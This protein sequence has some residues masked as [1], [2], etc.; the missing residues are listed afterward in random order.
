MQHMSLIRPIQSTT[1]VTEHSIATYFDS[2]TASKGKI[3]FD[4][5]R[6]L[7]C[8]YEGPDDTEYAVIEGQVQGTRSS[9]YSVIIIFDPDNDE[10]ISSDCSCPVEIDCK[11]G[12]ALMYKL[13]A[14]SFGHFTN[15][16]SSIDNSSIS[17][18]TLDKNT[19]VDS[20]ASTNV[21][22]PGL[23]LKQ[24]SN[25]STE[26]S[27]EWLT[28]IRALVEHTNNRKVKECVI[29]VLQKIPQASIHQV[30]DATHQITVSLMIGRQ[31]QNGE[32]KIVRPASNIAQMLNGTA[33]YI[34]KEDKEIAGLFIE[35]QT[36]NSNGSSAFPKD[37][38]V[39]EFLLHRIISTGRCLWAKENSILG[40][41]SA[42]DNGKALSLSP[43]KPGKVIWKEYDDG[44]QE[45]ISIVHKASALQTFFL[46][47]WYYIDTHEHSIGLLNLDLPDQ[48]LK[49]LASKRVDPEEATAIYIELSKSRRKLAIPLPK[50]NISTELI[51][52]RPKPVLTLVTQKRDHSSWLFSR[53]FYGHLQDI[54][55]AMLSF[56]YDGITFNEKINEHHQLIDNKLK[57][58]RRHKTA[59]YEFSAE[60][61]KESG[62]IMAPF[63]SAMADR[64]IIPFIYVGSKDEENGDEY[65]D[66]DPVQKWMTFSH[67]VIPKLKE[68]GWQIDFDPSFKYIVVDADEEWESDVTSG[69]SWWFSLKLGIT[70]DGKKM[71][72]FPI[73]S[74]VL[75]SL[76]GKE[77]NQIEKLNYDGYFYAPLPDG[78]KLALPFDRVRVVVQVLIELFDRSLINQDGSINISAPQACALLDSE[79]LSNLRWLGAEALKEIASKLKA[80]QGLEIIKEPAQFKGELR[81]YQRVGLG[82]LQFL[83]KYNLGGI[84]ADDM[85]LGKTAQTIAHILKE[86]TSK[87][88]SSPALIICPTSIVRNWEAE[89]RRFA[90]KLKTLCLHGSQ[91]FAYFKNIDKSD[92]VITTY[93]LLLKDY[94]QLSS[95]N[96]RI[97]VLDEAQA[98]K[99]PDSKVGILSSTLKADHRICLTG[100]PVQNHLGDLWSQFNFLM[101]GLLGNQSTFKKLFRTPIETFQDRARKQLLAQRLR[102][103]ILRRTKDE[104]AKELPAKTTM[105]RHVQLEGDQRDLYE[106]VR[107]AMHEKVREALAKKGMAKSQIIILDA[108]LK[109]RQVCCDPQLVKILQAGKVKGS[110][111]LNSLQELLNELLDEN[112]RILLFS[113]FTSMLDIIKTGLAETKT[114]FVEL[115]G[116]TKDR[117]TPI[118]Q[119]QS[120]RVPLFLIS[121]KAGGTGLNLTAADTVIH[122]DPWWNPAVEDQATDRAHRIGQTKPVLVIKLICQGTIEERMVQ[123]QE[124]KRIIAQGLYDDNDS[125]NLSLTEDDLEFLFSPIGEAVCD[126]V[127]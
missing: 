48:L 2:H 17:G 67:Q 111:K 94:S 73:L 57:I 101:P 37:D 28:S 108:L 98:I 100:T 21:L 62:L 96:W 64:N 92:M 103:F 36:D 122:Y 6:V 124:R 55:I 88:L 99:N 78:R 8:R 4:M 71:S 80:F 12:A 107:L 115:R 113:Q 81:D 44:R 46:S 54:T 118:Q 22:H 114:P 61:S 87:S 50:A 13:L 41:N 116:D 9:P 76:P 51:H 52:K 95:I 26:K 68:K 47:R 85:G 65:D 31:N 32:F 29:Y 120:G 38:K 15:D 105:L 19:I 104:V 39:A 83:A 49:N 102:P 79:V 91:R 1:L 34:G 77:R 45:L 110:A 53:S 33:S 123:L 119:F 43:A 60:L 63:S 70:V 7:S 11:H 84:L 56:D 82:W 106:T 66:E 16:K 127:A 90:P 27:V 121:L 69:G 89:A 3:Y 14:E 35:K 74:A 25:V 93:P 40:A 5:G 42:P 10:V 20:K 58:V 18:S 112:R 109:L 126:K 86:K 23:N 117:V 97:I 59:E 72:L 125:T 24:G 75:A 30:T